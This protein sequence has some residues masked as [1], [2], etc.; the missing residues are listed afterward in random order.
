MC[1]GPAGQ[2]GILTA[3]YRGKVYWFHGDTQRLSYAMGNSGATTG[4]PE[5]LDPDRGL[6][7]E[8]CVGQGGFARPMAPVGGEGVVWLYGVVAVPDD[9]GRERMAAFFLRLKSMGRV[10]DRGFVVYDDEEAFEEYR[11]GGPRPRPSSRPTTR[12]PSPTRPGRR[13]RTSPPPTRRWASGPTWRTTPTCPPTRH[14]LAWR[15]APAIGARTRR[16]SIGTPTAGR[17]SCC[18]TPRAPGTSIARNPS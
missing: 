14:T 2:D 17:R 5:A 1:A 4:P 3:A 9:G 6:E 12:S 15:R 13:T 16:S 11:G 8:Y 10:L 18:T 7:L